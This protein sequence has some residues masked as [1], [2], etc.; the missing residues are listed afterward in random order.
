MEEITELDLKQIIEI[1]LAKIRI[2]IILTLLFGVAAFSYTYFLVTP[3][4]TSSFSMYVYNAKSAQG[5]KT[6]SS[7]LDASKRLVNTYVAIIK[8]NSVLEKVEKAANLGYTANEIREMMSADAID[9]TEMLRVYIKNA[10]PEH[11]AM[12]AN[13]IA[14]VTPNELAYYVASSVKVIDYA[15]PAKEPSS[16]NIKNNVAIGAFLGLI[17]SI[18]FVLLKEIF[19]V[20]IKTEEDLERM[21][22]LPVLGAI[23]EINGNNEKDAYAYSKR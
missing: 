10:N 1:L 19:D 7:D 11:A 16:P 5:E 22:H 8:S 3:L 2:I 17:L 15:T 20:R 9:N 21:F 13:T 23:P 14:E 12:L 4:Y 6:N 18:T